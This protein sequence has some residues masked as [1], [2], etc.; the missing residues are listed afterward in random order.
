MANGLG[1]QARYQSQEDAI[2]GNWLA[3]D[4]LED[5]MLQ[6]N[7]SPTDII[8]LFVNS[9]QDNTRATKDHG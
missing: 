4:E 6:P 9:I 5:M 1:F 3:Y 2:N 7:K 8:S